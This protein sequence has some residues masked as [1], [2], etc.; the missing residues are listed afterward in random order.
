MI[1]LKLDMKKEIKMRIGMISSQSNP[2]PRLA[3]CTN[4]GRVL[5]VHAARDKFLSEGIQVDPISKDVKSYIENLNAQK[6]PL[7]LL[8]ERV[9]ALSK[10][11]QETLV[12]DEHK[13]RIHA[14]ISN[15]EKFICVGKNY[16]AHLKELVDN[17]LLNEVPNECTGFIK[18]NSVIVG[19][20]DEVPRPHGVVEFDYEPEVA[21]VIGKPAYRVK[22]EDAID[23]IFGFTLFNDL[24]AREVQRREV[25]SG[26]KFWTSKNMRNCGPVGPWIVTTDEI[27]DFHNLSVRCDVNGKHRMSLNTSGQINKPADIIE[28]FSRYIP[29]HPGDLFATGSDAGTAFSQPNAMD[30]YLRPGDVVD[31][32]MDG[33]MTLSNPITEERD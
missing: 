29:L 24:T 22:R 20:N 13:I 4:A 17:A 21:F 32:T 19:H 11:D 6:E 31:I 26:T 9:S 23:Y 16:G 18:L 1:A 14:P 5:D 2:T 25:I 33:V 8:I 15:P 27:G 30:L 3:V 28:H 7:N 10:V 12:F